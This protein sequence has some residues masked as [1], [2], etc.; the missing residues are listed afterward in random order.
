MICERA[1]EAGP[2]LTRSTLGGAYRSMSKSSPVEYLL[3]ELCV[4]FG[5]CDAGRD[6][7]RFEEVARLG[8]DAFTDQVLLAEGLDPKLEKRMWKEVRR[9]VSKRFADWDANG[10]S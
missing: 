3:S 9:Y 6:L 5:F 7:I 4:Q 8:P 1:G 10:A 2:P